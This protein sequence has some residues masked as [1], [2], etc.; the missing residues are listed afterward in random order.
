MQGNINDR[1]IVDYDSIRHD[2]ESVLQ[3]V[4]ALRAEPG[5]M[6]AI[7]Q[8]N[9]NKIKAYETAVERRLSDAFSIVIAGDFKRG[10]S[11][12]INAILGKSVAPVAVTPE[13]ATINRISYA[14]TPSVEAVLQNGKRARLALTELRR[15]QLEAIIRQ[16]PSEINYVD[17][18]EDA[19]ILK[20]VTIVDTPGMGELMKAF[21]EKVANYL[22]NADALIY[23]VSARAPLSLTEQSF[24]SSV[25]VPQSFSRVFL[26]LNMAD[27]L[28]T[29]ENIEKIR[30]LAI[31]RVSGISSSISVY[32][33]SAL[34][35][36][37]RKNALPRPEPELASQLEQNFLE[38]ENALK[39]DIILQKDIIKSMRGVAVVRVMLNDLLSRIRLIQ[40]SLKLNVDRLVEQEGAYQ[41]QN[42][43]LRT[44]V[45]QEKAALAEAVGEMKREA[46]IWMADFMQRVNAEISNLQYNAD[47]N[48]LERYL[49]FY[50]TDTVKEGVLACLSRHQKD[51]SERVSIS[52]KTLAQNL[53]GEALEGAEVQIAQCITDISWTAVDTA[54]FVANDMLQIGSQLGMLMLVGQAVAG[55][56]RQKTVSKKQRDFISPVLQGFDEITR[57]ILANLGDAYDT[58]KQTAINQ[59]EEMYESQMQASLDAIHQAREIHQN[60]DLHADEVIARL[61]E[62]RIS[63]ESLKDSLSKYD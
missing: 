51:I 5:F 59:V 4:R 31:S 17:I 44:R 40:S 62:A 22:V 14:Q 49:Q 50:M 37:C 58:L 42:S 54:M 47:T 48:T 46:R 25:V 9:L 16:L 56:I 15:E 21:D 18:R 34:D 63:I 29:E 28:E 20:E 36:Y 23:V 61:E 3:E 35:E 57:E 7:G 24:L 11:T 10:K 27:C 30:Q 38:F 33:L 52:G 13:T 55:F 43:E 6:Q 45:E 12:L 1:I 41:N 32:A 8:S 53:A 2:L 26:A 60:A 39:T 19:E